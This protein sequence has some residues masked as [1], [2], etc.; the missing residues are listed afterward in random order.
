VKRRKGKGEREKGKEREREGARARRR[1][2]QGSL[3]S[4]PTEDD[5]NEIISTKTLNV[6]ETQ[7][8]ILAP[9]QAHEMRDLH[10][11][12][13]ASPRSQQPQPQRRLVRLPTG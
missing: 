8:P 11:L 6:F 13:V 4:R 10:S 7:L 1:P 2:G 9:N 3:S 12:L 5:V